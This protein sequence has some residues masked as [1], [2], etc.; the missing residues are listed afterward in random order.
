MEGLS[1]LK[2]PRGLLPWDAPSP[3]SLAALLPDYQIH[4]LVGRGAMG[5]VYEA[6]Q[7]RLDRRV[8]LKLLPDELALD[9]E[10]GRRFLAEGR[11]LARLLHPRVVTVFD[12][13]ESLS[14]SLFLVMEFVDGETL[15]ARMRRGR[16]GVS[17]AVDWLRQ[18]SE[19]LAFAHELGV[20]HRDL[21]PA[22]ILLSSRGEVKVAD[23]G[24]S[25]L[26][27]GGGSASVDDYSSPSGTPGYSAPEQLLGH[28]NSG[29][30][31][32]VFSLGVIGYELLTGRRPAQPPLPPSQVAEI[33][34]RLDA[35]VL[36]AL[37]PD[38][39]ERHADA[40]SFLA[41]VQQAWDGI[42]NQEKTRRQLRR[43]RALAAA[44]AAISVAALAAGAVAWRQSH[45]AGERALVIA[46]T[47]SD[48][49]YEFA[50]HEM[51]AWPPAVA[52]FARA[53]RTNPDNK[54]A[55][56]RLVDL[57][58]SQ[59]WLLPVTP[60][61]QHG[62][63]VRWGEYN[64]DGRRI[65]SASDDGT[66]RIWDAK[67]GAPLTPPLMHG[68]IVYRASFSPDGT[69][70]LTISR[71]HFARIWKLDAPE[72][73]EIEID[74][75]SPVLCGQFSPDGLRI[76]TGCE[77]G[78]L[79]AWNA[80]SGSPVT[81]WMTHDSAVTSL[82]VS[83]NGQQVATGLR[84]N[85]GA[86]Q[87]GMR[88]HVWDIS[89]ATPSL[90]GDDGGGDHVPVQFSQDGKLVLLAHHR[91]AR[92]F[93]FQS[94]AETAYIDSPGWENF[95]TGLIRPDSRSVLLA[96]QV[97]SVQ[98]WNLQSGTFYSPVM[99]H[100]GGIT[101]IAF[102][103]DSRRFAAGTAR[104]DV[105][106][107]KSGDSRAL[108]V[109]LSLDGAVTRLQF[110]PDGQTLLTTST[111]GRVQQWDV[112]AG[113]AV[114]DV[115]YHPA[116]NVSCGEV[117]PDGQHFATFCG[118]EPTGRVSLWD[119]RTGELT[120]SAPP[121]E[122]AWCLN[123][124]PDGKQ[125]VVSYQR[126]A[127]TVYEV[128]SLK[129]LYDLKHEDGQGGISFFSPSGH[130]MA[131]TQTGGAVQIWNLGPPVQKGIALKMP[132]EIVTAIYSPDG[133]RI[134]TA[135][136]DARARIWDV[137]TGREVMAPLLHQN[138]VHF[139]EYS[140]DGRFIVTAASDGA[141]RVWDAE[142]GEP[143]L[144]P[145][146]HDGPAN[147]GRF[148]PDGMVI[149]SCGEDGRTCLWDA[150]TGKL[151]RQPI[152]YSSDVPCLSFSPDGTFFITTDN[153]YRA[154][155][156][157]V[158]DYGPVPEWFCDFAETV[159]MARLDDAGRVTASGMDLFRVKK[160]RLADTRD[161]QYAH[162]AR[163]FFQ[164]GS[165]RPIRPGSLRTV[166][167]HLGHLLSLEQEAPN[168]DAFLARPADPRV[169]A[170]LRLLQLKRESD[171]QTWL[172]T[173]PEALIDASQ[174]PEWW[175]TSDDPAPS[176]LAKAHSEIAGMWAHIASVIEEVRDTVKFPQ[177][178]KSGYQDAAGA[179]EK[180]EPRLH[181]QEHRKLA[182]ELAPRGA[183]TR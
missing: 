36:R 154:R 147:A 63:A 4:R 109:P 111:D 58:S 60:A 95:A 26:F 86:D 43:T 156:I 53:L 148:S 150:R 76:V 139:A 22:N 173:Y 89:Q 16:P 137:R 48:L 7:K 73:P 2:G 66:A 49:A 169:S 34:P 115:F 163:W 25:G 81:A 10:F 103:P 39:A 125:L 70:L 99:K 134:V 32:D 67:S 128:P 64:A 15:G 140:R 65:A 158:P 92:L 55:V 46:E 149:A 127:A 12:S 120:A 119:V 93:D 133:E 142:T 175:C 157:P 182:A 183:V 1:A 24:L 98:E 87:T 136:T 38:S 108:A 102:S 37:H 23:F 131:I 151:L 8:A 21:K 84:T 97:G 181:E 141:V 168:L 96:T 159:A 100:R 170:R 155:V 180:S 112:S 54:I 41:D 45:L 29:P 52:R 83:A 174:H 118:I 13:G 129:R 82:A 14:G 116:G 123:F 72:K 56:S 74:H 31:A 77:D 40:A 80:G 91:R 33:D 90:I 3:E 19:A 104:G 161:D 143:V 166:G 130:E 30:R 47:D 94:N 178:L 172:R 28:T 105:R 144:N 126:N 59:P 75:A 68:G 162:I 44:F 85:G 27:S 164:R 79:R 114:D 62:T 121:S 61:M 167:E 152:R 107:W 110:S 176:E 6:R 71:D 160:E 117:S 132:G 50:S 145:L 165:N 138:G 106:L 101:S 153:S 146:R 9:P 20:V 42:S 113:P 122:M 88:V 51:E 5:A 11:L 177:H 35:P 69:R 17:V 171:L 18:I 78:R 179:A 57:L 124:R 135:S